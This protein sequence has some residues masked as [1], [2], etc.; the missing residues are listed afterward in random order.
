MPI[1]GSKR[2][3]LISHRPRSHFWPCGLD[4]EP[5]DWAGGPP[6]HPHPP[7]SLTLSFRG[8]FALPLVVAVGVGVGVQRWGRQTRRGAFVPPLR[9]LSPSLALSCIF[10]PSLI[11]IFPRD[12]RPIIGSPLGPSNE[13]R[14]RSLG[15]APRF[16]CRGSSSCGGLFSFV[17][18][19]GSDSRKGFKIGGASSF[20]NS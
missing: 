13:P 5:F 11:F 17:D 6:R 18:L 12:E 8:F 20:G 9:F 4:A 14:T 15:S 1:S 2:T 3:A 10:D 16:L 7:P 19:S